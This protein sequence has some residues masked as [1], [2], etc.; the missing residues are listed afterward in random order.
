MK[1]LLLAT[2][3]HILRWYGLQAR[4]NIIFIEE[5]DLRVFLQELLVCLCEFIKYAN[6]FSNIA[7]LV[8]KFFI[9]TTFFVVLFLELL[10][11]FDELITF[12]R[13]AGNRSRSN[14]KCV[15]EATGLA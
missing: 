13:E 4:R 15:I 7:N 1:L 14:T 11:P 5:V 9:A 6:G 12:K 2:S 10:V 8:F 3:Q